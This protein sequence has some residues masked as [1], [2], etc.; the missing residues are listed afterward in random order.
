MKILRLHHLKNSEIKNDFHLFFVKIII[1]HLFYQN[2]FPKNPRYH[3]N[4]F[5]E[6][7]YYFNASFRFNFK[8][9]NVD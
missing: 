1:S 3:L 7:N 5:P 9:E 4:H 2:C 8:D 6:L